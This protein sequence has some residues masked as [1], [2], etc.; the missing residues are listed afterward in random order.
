MTAT[1]AQIVRRPVAH[2]H[3]DVSSQNRVNEG[4]VKTP[5]AR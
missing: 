4:E 2:T 5:A 1:I 3:A